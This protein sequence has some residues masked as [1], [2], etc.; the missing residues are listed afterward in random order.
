[1]VQIVTVENSRKIF[2]RR[3]NSFLRSSAPNFFLIAVQL[4]EPCALCIRTFHAGRTIKI[5]RRVSLGMSALRILLIQFES[6]SHTE[7]HTWAIKLPKNLSA[8]NSI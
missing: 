5:V 3:E 7:S 1:M 8:V 6:A 4:L 2:D